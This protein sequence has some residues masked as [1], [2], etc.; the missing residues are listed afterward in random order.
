M[1]RERCK[2][3]KK[4]SAAENS[5]EGCSIFHT[6]CIQLAETLQVLSSRLTEVRFSFVNLGVLRG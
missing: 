1:Q 4:A 3:K 2:G 5:L 6:C